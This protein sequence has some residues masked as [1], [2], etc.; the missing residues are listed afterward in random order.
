L[1]PPPLQ[2]SAGLRRR[3]T[4]SKYP[5]SVLCDLANGNADAVTSEMVAKACAAADPTAEEVI[6]ETLDLLAYWLGSI[7]H[8]LEPEVIVIGGGVSTM[9]APLL[10]KIR[11]R[12]RGA[13]LHPARWKFHWY[14]LATA[15]TPESLALLHSVDSSDMCNLYDVSFE[16]EMTF[17]RTVLSL[18]PVL[19]IRPPL[20]EEARHT[21]VALALHSDFPRPPK[22]PGR[23]SWRYRAA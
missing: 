13:C 19:V 6:R 7:S 9:L 16:S 11:E 17:E 14:S 10:N 2:P 21:A 5:K 20:P 1:I 3:R 23:E 15:K 8:L 4:N 18:A 22:S 12:W